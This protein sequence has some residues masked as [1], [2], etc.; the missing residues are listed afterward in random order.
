MRFQTTDLIL[1]HW[2]HDPAHGWLGVP[3]RMLLESGVANEISTCSYLSRKTRVAYLEEDCDASKF[4][5]AIGMSFK[6]AAEI[7]A[8][9][10]DGHCFVRQMPSYDTSAMVMGPTS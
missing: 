2:Y 10:Y 6:E 8:T 9:R 1:L 7:P 5:K 4:L 3:V